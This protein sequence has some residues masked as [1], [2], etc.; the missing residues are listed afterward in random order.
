L[1]YDR[2]AS[3]DFQ[4]SSRSLAVSYLTAREIDDATGFEKNFSCLNAFLNKLQENAKNLTL[5]KGN[6]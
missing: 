3:Q 2:A 1:D 4:F 5:M 6:R